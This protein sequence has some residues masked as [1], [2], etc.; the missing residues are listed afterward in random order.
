MAAIS[1]GS[2]VSNGDYAEET[3]FN[4]CYD[5]VKDTSTGHDHD[6]TDSKYIVTPPIGSILPW[7]KSISGVPALPTGWMECDGSTVSDAASPINGQAVP[8]L[9][10]ASEDTKKFLRGAAASGGAGTSY[11]HTHSNPGLGQFSND[12]SGTSCARSTDL[13]GLNN[14]S[15]VPPYYE[16]VFII[17]FK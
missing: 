6:G 9:N 4:D 17:R 2:T 15:H 1:W 8:N 3:W 10:G 7:A 13:N 11:Q 16:V 12:G 5:S 14:S